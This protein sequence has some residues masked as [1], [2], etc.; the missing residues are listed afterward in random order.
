MGDSFDGRRN[1]FP[2]R[3]A[4]RVRWAFSSGRPK[5]MSTQ[6]TLK[7]V[8][9]LGDKWDGTPFANEDSPFCQNLFCSADCAT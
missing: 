1:S 8:V 9:H 5:P 7:G 6:G 2:G 4:R 3:D